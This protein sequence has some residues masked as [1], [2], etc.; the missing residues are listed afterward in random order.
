VQLYGYGSSISQPLSGLTLV[1][2]PGQYTLQASAY[3][4]GTYTQFPSTTIW[5]GEPVATP[6]GSSV[7]VTLTPAQNPDLRIDLQFPSVTGAGITTVVETPL[8]PAPPQGVAALCPQNSDG[9]A[10]PPVY[11][12]IQTTA[13]FSGTAT[14]C[15]RRLVVDVPNAA[16]EFLHLY[17]YNEQATP[18]HWE[19]LPAP[20]GRP[21]A[22]DC[23][24]GDPASLAA[25]GCASEADCGI[26][27]FATPSRDVFLVCGVTTSFSPYSLFEDKITFTNQVDGHVYS[28]ATG[29]LQHWTVP[30]DATYRITA[31]GAQ[32]GT[33]LTAAAGISGGCGAQ[34]AGDFALHKGDVLDILVGQQGT[35]AQNNAGGGG[36]TFVVKNGVPLVIAGGGGGVRSTATTSGRPGAT[37]PSGVSGSTSP[38]YTGSFIPGGSN[39]A[40]GLRLASWGAGGGGWSGNGA[41]DGAYGDGGASFL[42]PDHGKGGSGRSCGL[43]ADGGY[44]GGGAGNGCF[45]A[46]GGGGY[47][48]GGGGRVAGGGGS[49]NN[50]L[51]PRGNAGICTASGHGMVTIELPPR[52]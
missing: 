37:G 31:T 14:V 52:P 17:H 29:T 35:A 42:G 47:S 28:G 7:P 27:L 30:G 8:G 18:N 34:I 1:A 2:E 48:G 32:G 51:N 49:L 41:S 50:G 36:G 26:D 44:G 24:D 20:P 43:P 6:A 16:A 4:N 25:C 38:G 39:G 15:V 33:A 10:C 5:F 23:G 19:Q 12:D 11:Y 9:V 45:G 46:G 21:A 40:G 13:Q 3:V 22:I